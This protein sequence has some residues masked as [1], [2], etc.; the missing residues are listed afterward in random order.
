MEPEGSLPHLQQL[1][2]F[3]C[4]E[5]NQSSP[6]PSSHFLKIHFNFIFPYKPGSSK[7][8]LSLRSPNQNPVGISPLPNHVTCPTYLKLLD[9]ITRKIFGEEEYRSLSSSLCSFLHSPFTSSTRHNFLFTPS[10]PI[11]LHFSKHLSLQ[12]NT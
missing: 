3:P 8:S 4:P 7:W 5:P 1:A 6:C 9:L 10:V 11:A 2:T 12:R